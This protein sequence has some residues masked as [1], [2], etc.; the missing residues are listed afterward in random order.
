[1]KLLNSL[2]LQSKIVFLISIP[3][4]ALLFFMFWQLYKTYD[5]LAQNKDLA[6]QI[7]ISKYLSLLVH[8]MQ[9]ERGMS[10][11]FLSSNGVQ[12]DAELQEQRKYTDE[13]LESLIRFIESTSGLN[14]NYMQALQNGLN[15]LSKLPQ[16]RNSMNSDNKKDILGDTVGYFTQS[17]SMLLDT[18]LE[19]IKI[20]PNFRISNEVLGYVN[21]LYAKEMSGLERATANGIFSANIPA[22]TSQYNKLINLIAKQEVFEKFFLSFGDSQS[23]LLFHNISKDSSFEDVQSMRKVLIDKYLVGNF[24]INPSAW[25]DTI[26]KKIDLLKQVEDNINLNLAK[27]IELEIADH[28]YYFI[29]IIICEALLISITLVLSFLVVRSIC[30]RLQDVNKELEYIIDSK[31]FTGKIAVIANDEISS[32]VKSVNAFID[33]M[34]HTLKRIFSQIKNNIVISKSLSNISVDLDLNSKKI[35]EISYNNTDLSHS[36]RQ[37]LD[38]SIACVNLSRELLD[39]VLKNVSDTK[40]AVDVIYEHVQ[41]SMQDEESN[42]IK[43]QS[44][45]TE[46]QNIQSV[47]DVITDI[48]DQTNLLALN[49]AIEAARAG[50]HGRG[51]AV[52]ADEVR[53]LAERTQKSITETESIIKNILKSIVE[54]NEERKS[55]LQSMHTLS[56]RSSDMQSNVNNLSSVIVN[57]VDQSL[58][59]LNNINRI[60]ENTT[61]ILENGEKIASCVEDLLN[62]NDSMQKSS[63]ELNKQ[64][65]DLNQFLSMFKV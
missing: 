23:V 14:Y 31:T 6:N 40:N 60:N 53:N 4:I 16:V 27:H 59:N 30:K 10:A 19:S 32:M 35:K 46:A 61:S 8:E 63:S 51:F 21:F 42:A 13:K 20:I 22:N 49:A 26:T 64:T 15:L 50:E 47:L 9:K 2:K 57:V 37:I 3:M 44:L 12:F 36:S 43:M 41:N 58:M 29:F 48:A 52:V 24:D 25:F 34:Q 17:I 33:Y 7:E 1:M 65:V 28:T 38:E 56:R 62:I 45:S 5:L 39:G 11:G 54:I 18:L 55:N